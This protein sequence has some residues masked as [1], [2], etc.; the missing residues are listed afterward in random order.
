[1]S[2]SAAVSITHALFLP[3]LY[4]D[5]PFGEGHQEWDDYEV[6]VLVGGGI[7]VTPFTSILKDLVFKSS[8]KSKIRCRKV[9]NSPDSFNASSPAKLRPFNR[10]FAGLLH[11]GDANTAP[12]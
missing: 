1:M 10:H 3:K 7:G 2:P 11:L 12:V 6:S 9:P 5:G 8:V 4:L